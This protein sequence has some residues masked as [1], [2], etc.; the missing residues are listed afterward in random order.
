MSITLGLYGT[1]RTPLKRESATNQQNVDLPPLRFVLKKSPGGN[2][3]QVRSLPPAPDKFDDRYT[4]LRWPRAA[5]TLPVAAVAG[6]SD[7][8]DS[9]DSCLCVGGART[10]CQLRRRS[11][12]EGT[13]RRGGAPIF[14]SDF[15]D[16][17]YG[18]RPKRTAHQAVQRVSEAVRDHGPGQQG[19]RGV[20]VSSRG[21]WSRAGSTAT[22]LTESEC[23]CREVRTISQR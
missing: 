18:Y 15:Q 16:G 5:V 4:H 19:L 22:A 23:V 8:A 7:R 12:R 11:D 20:S 17:S 10:P 14:A 2:P 1:P 9:S 21:R 6:R 3:V 13:L